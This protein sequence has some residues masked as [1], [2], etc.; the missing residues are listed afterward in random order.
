MA[1]MTYIALSAKKIY[2]PQMF[3]FKSMWIF[4]CQLMQQGSSESCIED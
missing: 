3:G 1:D 2:T 4:A